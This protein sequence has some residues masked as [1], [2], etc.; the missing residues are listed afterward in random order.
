[1]QRPNPIESPVDPTM[2][3]AER[4]PR[5]ALGADQAGYHAKETIKQ[6]LTQAGYQV[7]D[8]GT[9]SEESVDYPVYVRAV[10]QKVRSGQDQLSILACG[11]GIGMA[12]TANK[13]PGIRA[14]VAH[15]AMTARLAREYNDAN[16]LALG[17]RVVNDPGALEIVRDFLSALRR[18]APPTA[19]R[20]DCGTR[21]GTGAEVTSA[22][23]V[24]R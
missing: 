7:D 14:A 2:P 19:H 1:M 24:R 23:A 17:G 12:I 21:P 13:I 8:V 10:G 3:E 4:K 5:I 15:D 20:R 22:T 18:R 6:F 9:W 16:V 11:T